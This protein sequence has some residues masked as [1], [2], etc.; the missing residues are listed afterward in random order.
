MQPSTQT[1]PPHVSVMQL[2]LGGMISGAVGALARLGVPDHLDAGPLSAGELAPKVGAEPGPLYRLM[3]ACASVGVLS[4][5]PDGKFS[6]TPMSAILR[7][8]G[9]IS[10]RGWAMFSSHEVHHQGWEHL[11]YCVRTGKQALPK[12][13]G[14]Q[15]FELMQER[16]DIAA[17]FNQAMT[18]LSRLDSPAVAAAYSFEGIRSLM[19]VAGGHGLLLA[20][21]LQHHPHL[22]GT[23]YE[24]PSVIEGARNGPLQPLMNRCALVE[25][26][27]FT[28]IPPGSDAY[29]MKHIIHDWPDELSVKILKGCRAGV[30]PGGKLL[31][32][33]SV[34]Q[35]GNDFD[36]G[37]FLDLE[38][39]IFPGGLERTE[40]QFRELF[41][42]SGWRLSRIIPTTAGVSIVEGIPA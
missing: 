7:S 20:T 25:G 30:N 11:E 8:S 33:D 38:M 26:D 9:P 34:I 22:R 13:Y 17:V 28:S 1:I 42:A 40:T 5:G 3:R 10:L 39:L 27:M 12:I 36:A 29:I 35:P 14:K 15:P 16:H 6:Q 4:E 32:V 24:I 21:I 31:V 37:K 2:V 18:D 41:A 19:D 23:L